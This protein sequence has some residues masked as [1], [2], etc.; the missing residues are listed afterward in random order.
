MKTRISKVYEHWVVEFPFGKVVYCK[1][2]S[3]AIAVLY[4]FD[5]YLLL[6]TLAA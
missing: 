3:T 5:A 1:Y 2:W 4:D 6:N